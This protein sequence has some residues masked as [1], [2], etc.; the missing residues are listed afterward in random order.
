MRA[1]TPTLTQARAL[2]GL[3]G[4]TAPEVA[5]AAFRAAIKAARPDMP[6][7][8]AERFRQI[9]AAYRILQAEGLRPALAAPKRRPAPVPVITLTPREAIAGTRRVISYRRRKLA[10]HVPAG[11][12][13][14]EHLRL[15][16]AGANGA[17]LYLPVL[18]RAAQGLSI[19]G[20]DLF[21]TCSVASRTLSDGGRIEIETHAG[22]RTAWV[23]AGLQ[24]PIRIC[25]KGLGL[26]ARGSRPSGRLFVT[27]TPAADAPSAAEDLLARF[28][29]VWTPDRLAA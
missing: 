23:V 19:L 15:K 1:E 6:G 8:D 12:R 11:L 9:I 21:M 4:P 28:T 20:D 29:R 17:D 3:N 16:G 18:V 25:L 10:V 14:G 13:T 7:G 26:P 27:L 5:A 24:S 2:L 22:P